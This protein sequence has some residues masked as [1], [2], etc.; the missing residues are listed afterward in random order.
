MYGERAKEKINRRNFLH[1]AAAAGAGLAFS[2][3]ASV[4]ANG[5]KKPD[6]INVALLGAGEMNQVPGH[7]IRIE[8]GVGEPDLV[9]EQDD[10][11]RPGPPHLHAVKRALLQGSEPRLKILQRFQGRLPVVKQQGGSTVASGNVC[12]N[13][14]IVQNRATH[15]NYFEGQNDGGPEH[16]D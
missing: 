16:K 5:G 13:C 1:S 9:I 7:L 14:D 12:Q 6:D 15:S 3:G 8:P 4:R 11:D 2:Q 10:A